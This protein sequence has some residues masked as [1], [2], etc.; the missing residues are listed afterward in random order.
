MRLATCV[1]LLVFLSS[2]SAF[3]NVEPE[4]KVIYVEIP[5]IYLQKC[6]IPPLPEDNGEMAEAYLGAAQCAI[7][8]NR[9]KAKIREITG[10]EL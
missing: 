9:D 3:R 8:G 6:D 10:S 2:C 7:R 5:E 1:F 4:V